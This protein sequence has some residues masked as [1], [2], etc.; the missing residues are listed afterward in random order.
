M[1]DRAGA[2]TAPYASSSSSAAAPAPGARAPAPAARVV[3]GAHVAPID[4]EV[5]LTRLADLIESGDVAPGIG[6]LSVLSSRGDCSSPCVGVGHLSSKGYVVDSDSGHKFR[7]LAMWVAWH[8]PTLY[9]RARIPRPAPGGPPPS[10]RDLDARTLRR[11][12]AAAE[13]FRVVMYNRQLLKH[14]R[15]AALDRMGAAA[16]AA[17]A[18]PPRPSSTAAAGAGTGALQQLADAALGACGSSS[19]SSRGSHSADGG[20]SD[21]DGDTADASASELSALALSSS[22]SSSPPLTGAA[23]VLANDVELPLSPLSDAEPASALPAAVT[24]SAAEVA[25][26][27]LAAAPASAPAPASDSSLA[28]GQAPVPLT[29]P[30]PPQAVEPALPT[31]AA[32][33]ALPVSALA[34]G[35]SSQAVAVVETAASR[36]DDEGSRA[37]DNRVS[38]SSTASAA[39]EAEA[40]PPATAAGVE[41]QH[42]EVQLPP[43]PPPQLLPQPRLRF[44]SLSRVSTL[45]DLCM[46]AAPGTDEAAATAAVLAATEPPLHLP[47]DDGVGAGGGDAHMEADDGAQ[48]VPPAAGLPAEA[49][50]VIDSQGAPVAQVPTPPCSAVDHVTPV[51]NGGDGDD[52]V[53]YMDVVHEASPPS[54]VTAAAPAGMGAAADSAEAAPLS[55]PSE[56]VSVVAPATGNLSASTPPPAGAPEGSSVHGVDAGIA[57]GSSSRTT[58]IATLPLATADSGSLGGDDDALSAAATVGSAGNS[59]SRD[60][61]RGDG[62]GDASSS[63][64]PAAALPAVSGT[65]WRPDASA[66]LTPAA[67]VPSVRDEENETA[68]QP[69]AGGLPL[70]SAAPAADG[71][72]ARAAPAVVVTDLTDDADYDSDGSDSVVLVEERPPPPAASSSAAAPPSSAALALVACAALSTADV[73][74]G[75]F[76]DAALAFLD[77]AFYGAGSGACN[78]PQLSV[79]VHTRIATETAAAWERMSQAQ[80]D[81]A[82]HAALASSG[83]ERDALA[84]QLGPAPARQRLHISCF[85]GRSPL[86]YVLRGAAAHPPAGAALHVSAP[87]AA[88]A[89]LPP[90]GSSAAG[91]D[92]K[93]TAVVSHPGRRI[94]IFVDGNPGRLW[95]RV[96]AAA[97][98][99]GGAASGRLPLPAAAAPAASASA[100]AASATVAVVGRSDSRNSAQAPASAAAPVAAPI[101]PP[102]ALPLPAPSPSASPPSHRSDVS[103]CASTVPVDSDPEDGDDDEDVNGNEQQAEGEVEGGIDVGDV[104]GGRSSSATTGDAGL[105]DA[106]VVAAPA[107]PATTGIALQAPWV[108]TSQAAAA[109]TDDQL[110]QPHRSATAS[111]P[112]GGSAPAAPS[113]GDPQRSQSSSGATADFATFVAA[114]A[115]AGGAASSAAAAEPEDAPQPAPAKRPRPSDSDGRDDAM[116][117]VYAAA[118]AAS[119]SDGGHRDADDDATDRPAHKRRALCDDNSRCT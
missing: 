6:V 18:L 41:P 59:C 99:A 65:T 61:S 1:A 45:S 94:R 102:L 26:A 8:D 7:T 66:A 46:P 31:A 73:H 104:D 36:T 113:S 22:L 9:D 85:D 96:D 84:G 67:A 74:A 28:G 110:P 47:G 44:A 16:A 3:P 52:A 107:A 97:T 75:D 68:R 117:G 77:G 69:P 17:A 49:S 39:P 48:T 91:A 119:S 114:A 100:T 34:A 50:A 71:V 79:E 98:Y 54:Q 80:R 109:A 21:A 72:R 64:L 27:A 76:D 35:L 62:D 70:P 15:R 30:T 111:E 55:I 51:S 23:A 90:S 87:E 86:R 103:S 112:Q 53:V 43:P 2:P 57:S 101:V 83:V 20:G 40:L 38:P 33:S 12:V 106:A 19:S 78:L 93:W 81:T 25:A 60:A 95:M 13:P 5:A 4:P 42:Q 118:E 105:G 116:G 10:E 37:D 56:E 89:V 108:S 32:P 14:V 58:T 24:V 29:P 92:Y 115:Q 63:Q 11:L 82:N 88:A